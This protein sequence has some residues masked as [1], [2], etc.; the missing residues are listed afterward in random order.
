M[1]IVQNIARKNS[2]LSPTETATQYRPAT[3]IFGRNQLPSSNVGD[4]VP[5]VFTSKRIPGTVDYNNSV[6]STGGNVNPLGKNLAVATMNVTAHTCPVGQVGSVPQSQVPEVG[7]HEHGTFFATQHG[8]NVTPQRMSGGVSP[9][10]NTPFH[11]VKSQQSINR[12]KRHPTPAGERTNAASFTSTNTLM[13]NSTVRGSRWAVIKRGAAD[14]PVMEPVTQVVNGIPLGNNGQRT[15]TGLP[16]TNPQVNKNAHVGGGGF[17]G[18][19]PTGRPR[20]WINQQSGSQPI[21]HGN[22]FPM[23]LGCKAGCK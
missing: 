13:G 18:A 21:E 4:A 1:P 11:P 2:R 12:P 19:A 15:S 14:T 20:V 3:N 10:T 16:M 7:L 9:D 6:S 17:T 23:N 22:S 8:Q 5:T